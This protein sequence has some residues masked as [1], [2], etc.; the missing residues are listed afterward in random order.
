MVTFSESQDHL[1]KSRTVQSL[2]KKIG[3]Q[4]SP[5]RLML[6]HIVQDVSRVLSLEYQSCEINLVRASTNQQIATAYSVPPNQL[7]NLSELCAEVFDFL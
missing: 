1:N 5:H 7:R 2:K 6:K 3:S 4:K